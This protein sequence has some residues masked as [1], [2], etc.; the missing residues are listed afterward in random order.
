MK[1]GHEELYDTSQEAKKDCII[2]ISASNLLVSHQRHESCRTNCYILTGTKY[3]IH[4]TTHKRRI[5]SILEQNDLIRLNISINSCLKLKSLPA[6]L[7]QL[8]RHMRVLEA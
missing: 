3:C 4:E 7:D 1:D 2:R 8:K 5:Q 6:A